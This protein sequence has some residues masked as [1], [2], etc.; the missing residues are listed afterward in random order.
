MAYDVVVV[1]SG[2]AGSVIAEQLASTGKSVLILD[3][4][5]H[6]GGNCYDY[7]HGNILIQKYGPHIFHTDNKQ[8]FDYLSKFTK[9]NDYQHKVL[10]DYQGEHYPIPINLDTVNKYYNLNLNSPNE[11]KIFLES[12]REKISDIKNS[13]DVVVSKFGNELYEA[14]VK[15]Y[16]KKQWDRYPQELHRMVLERLPIRYD[17]NP[18]YFNDEFQ[19]MPS[20]GFT[21]LFTNLLNH[22]N[23]KIALNTDFFDVVSRLKT[24]KIIYTGP[25]DR[26]FNHKY[27]PLKYRGINFV[28]EKHSIPSFQV[29]SVINHPDINKDFARVTEFKKFY[30]L[31]SNETVIC[32]EFFTWDGEP[33]YP[34]M[35]ENNLTLAKKYLQEANNKKNV[36]F[37]GR[38]AEYRYLNMDKAVEAALN[39]AKTLE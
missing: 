39:L 5:D 8:V 24:S 22:K 21:N 14:F 28:F 36:Y 30:N 3:K 35:D 20:K 34:L 27:G 38:L 4:R 37:I 23:I 29:N 7:N 33:S 25:I 26:F 13:R 16:T 10:A 6:I 11:L 31:D 19:G 18:N 32:K 9:W 2:F 17:R 15:H 12:I 1:G